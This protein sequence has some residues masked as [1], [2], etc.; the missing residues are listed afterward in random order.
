[1]S[2]KVKTV[3]TIS[4]VRKALFAQSK[5]VL[6]NFKSACDSHLT[7]VGDI[8]DHF[9]KL[10]DEGN[11]NFREVIIGNTPQANKK[12]ETLGDPEVIA[13]CVGF[14][15][16]VREIHAQATFALYSTDQIKAKGGTKKALEKAR[17]AAKTWYVEAIKGTKRDTGKAT[18]TFKPQSKGKKNGKVTDLVEVADQQALNYARSILALIDLQDSKKNDSSSLRAIFNDVVEYHAIGEFQ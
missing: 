16:G 13:H 8:R 2:K 15:S 18:G 9:E 17:N 12:N 10:G 5:E 11:F 14:A 6:G 3:S 1:M 4:N 7:A